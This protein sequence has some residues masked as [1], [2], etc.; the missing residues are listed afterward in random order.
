MAAHKK[1]EYATWL[2]AEQFYAH[3]E[4]LDRQQYLEI[5]FRPHPGETQYKPAHIHSSKLPLDQLLQ[6]SGPE[7]AILR[8]WQQP[9][10]NLQAHVSALQ[11][12]L[13]EFGGPTYD[14][15]A[16]LEGLHFPR[17]VLISNL[18]AGLPLGVGEK[19]HLVGG[20]DFQADVHQ[21]P[22]DDAS[23]SAIFAS[24]MPME[25]RGLR[26]S[27][28]VLEP[29]GLLFWGSAPLQALKLAQAVGF[30]LVKAVFATEPA[31]YPFL[32]H[33]PFTGES[34]EISGA[35]SFVFLKPKK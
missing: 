13:V 10:F 20:V 25:R 2:P 22:L 19:R 12:Q 14:E 17:G 11:H 4:L 5:V 8:I 27:I 3:P 9:G 15:F 31:N 1:A 28:R 26:E 33:N 32:E 24:A 7:Q 18:E 30:D 21:M 35:V 16:V 34:I 29:G 23:T 6:P